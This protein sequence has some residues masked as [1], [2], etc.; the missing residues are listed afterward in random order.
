MAAAEKRN[1]SYESWRRRQERMRYEVLLMLYKAS[2]AQPEREVK[3]WTF[4]YNLGVWEEEMG[5]AIEWLE[6]AGYLRCHRSSLEISITLKGIRYIE[7][8][9]V[10]RR[11]IRGISPPEQDQ[12]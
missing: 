7:E 8:G 12:P 2:E 9:A 1:E 10:R 11:T 5:H 3:A 4:A 6:R